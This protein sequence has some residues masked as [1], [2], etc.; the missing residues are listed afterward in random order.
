MLVRCRTR[1]VSEIQWM[2][3]VCTRRR[4]GERHLVPLVPPTIRPL[5]WYYP[6]MER[7]S[8]P[9]RPEL[10]LEFDTDKQLKRGPCPECG[11]KLDRDTL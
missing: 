2:L 9:N 1:N 3:C 11:E 7:I 4:K 6:G 8:L 10:A 5:R